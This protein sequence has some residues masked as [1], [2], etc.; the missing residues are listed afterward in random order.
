MAI[1]LVIA[2]A[3]VAVGV[4]ARAARRRRTLLAARPRIHNTDLEKLSAE[5]LADAKPIATASPLRGMRE[6]CRSDVIDDSMPPDLCA[7]F[8]HMD[9]EAD[10]E[11]IQ[12][13]STATYTFTDTSGKTTTYASL[14]EMPP[15]IRRFFRQFGS[16]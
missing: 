1:I 9:T 14:A 13:Q 4:G 5:L 7:A 3:A 16:W 11:G 2:V 12:V 10:G 8:N 6:V 15:D